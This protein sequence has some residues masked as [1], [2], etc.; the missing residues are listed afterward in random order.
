MAEAPATDDRLLFAAALAHP[1]EDTPRL[2]LADW[3]DEHD[4]PELATALRAN[5][6]MV[7]FLAD[8]ARWDTSPSLRSWTEMA[9]AAG[10]AF[11][12]VAAAR[13]MARYLDLFPAPPGA[14]KEYREDAPLE[15][16]HHT[17][18]HNPGSFL[19]SWEYQRQKQ[20]ASLREQAAR[21][22]AAPGPHSFA[23]VAQ[24]RAFE[25][26]NCLLHELILRGRPLTALPGAAEHAARMRERN[27][28]LAW[29]PLTRLPPDPD[30]S[31]YLP[32]FGPGAGFGVGGTYS[33]G[34]PL[35]D[36]PGGAGVPVV[37]ASEPVAP[38]SLL[39][40][41]VAGWEEES[42]GLLEGVLFRLERPLHAAAAGRS[43][44]AALPADSLGGSTR[45]AGWF[46]NRITAAGALAMLFCAS[47]GG[48][49]YGRTE[50]GA[51]G[52]LHAWQSLGALAGCGPAASAEA[53]AAGAERCEWLAF[54]GTD[55]FYQI[56]PDLGLI[57]VQPDRRTV[58]L[59]A[60]TD[61][62]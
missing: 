27:H 60:A 21:S 10:E 54:G 61:T 18:P 43:W 40:A 55:W 3:F 15:R 38:E 37:V 23:G 24:G 35:A 19:S 31:R 52:R 62:D 45:G 22:A 1:A 7:A 8:L 42:N 46:V 26:R 20:I 33:T 39:F 34:V 28:P 14:P 29:L 12:V 13:L 2:A 5:P 17:D 48:G 50:W 36:A 57:C 47:S 32:H 53:L 11:P 49:A 4:E 6:W 25:E 9:H 30:L 58:A 51:Y 41:A 16:K 56:T 59:L 44:F